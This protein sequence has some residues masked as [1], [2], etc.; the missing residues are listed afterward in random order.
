MRKV[1]GFPLG[2]GLLAGL[3]SLEFAVAAKPPSPT[4]TPTPAPTGCTTCEIVYAKKVK[5][6]N[7]YRGDLLLMKTDGANKTLLLAGARDVV[8]AYPRWA[9]DGEWIAFYTKASDKGSIRVIRKDGTGLTTVASTCVVYQSWTAWR[10]VATNNGYWL[11][12]QDAR[13]SDGSCIVETAPYRSNLWAVDVSLGSSVLI[14]SRV[15]LT[16]DLNAQDADLWGFPA[17][18]RDGTHLSALQR[19]HDDYDNF[20][21]FDVSFLSGSPVLG[22]AW[23][24][25]PPEFE[26]EK[27]SPPISW[28]NQ[29]DWL[30]FRSDNLDGTDDIQ[31]YEVDLTEEPE[32]LG[33]KTVLVSGTSY[34]FSVGLDWSPDDSQ[35][36]GVVGGTGSTST[37]GIYVIT[38]GTP[39]SMQLLAP[40]GSDSVGGPDWKPL[41]P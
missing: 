22:H 23:L 18:S 9:P 26:P 3:L 33:E 4:P 2:V 31:R 30:A 29:H 14:G 41:V 12:Y 37:D 39:F 40:H 24:F 10:P 5:T 16:C 17:W 1:I 27:G 25:A 34:F 19:L 8:N 32:T 36:V 35:L 38:P 7:T 21:V 28:G 15:C 20:Y 11:V 13:K 6:G